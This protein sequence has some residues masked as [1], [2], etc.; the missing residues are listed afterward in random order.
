M[1]LLE[2]LRGACRLTPAP[3]NIFK[4]G[5]T[6]PKKYTKRVEEHHAETAK[7]LCFGQETRVDLQVSSGHHCTRVK[8]LLEQYWGKFKHLS[9]HAWATSFLPLVF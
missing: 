4:V 8:E 9:G 6:S 7:V 3:E 5:T 1:S 2:E